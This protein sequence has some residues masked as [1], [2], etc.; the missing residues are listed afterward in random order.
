MSEAEHCDRLAIMHSGRIVA[1]DSPS[2]LKAQLKTEVGE[3][4]TVRAKNP[5][6]ALEKLR[7]MFPEAS[8][9]GDRIH[10]FALDVE[11]AMQ[12]I[13][14]ALQN[15]SSVDIVLQEPTLED[16]FIHRITELERAERSL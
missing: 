2:A 1:Y 16:V 9:F 5:F 11:R 10:V 13:R 6:L 15:G 7:S 8:F 4:L 3:L 12:Q 14:E